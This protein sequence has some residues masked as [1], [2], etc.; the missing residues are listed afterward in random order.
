MISAE[1]H[2]LSLQTIHHY[3]GLALH[4][5]V[6]YVCLRA[7]IRE[8]MCVCAWVH[9]CM[10]VYMCVYREEVARMRSV[11]KGTWRGMELEYVM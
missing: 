5:W 8:C 1:V 3:H 2:P 10:C 4:T 6:W 11:Y 9:V 7:W